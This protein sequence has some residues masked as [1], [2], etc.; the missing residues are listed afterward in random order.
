MREVFHWAWE[1]AASRQN[2][3]KR[4]IRASWNKRRAFAKPEITWEAA[5][6]EY[7]AKIRHSTFDI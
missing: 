3:N 6:Q 7:P 5:W 1:L 2:K 4:I